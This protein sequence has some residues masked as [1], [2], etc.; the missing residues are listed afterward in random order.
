MKSDFNNT[1]GYYSAYTNINDNS[2]G[3]PLNNANTTRPN[4]VTATSSGVPPI[5]LNQTSLDEVEKNNLRMSL[6]SNAQF[7][8][9]PYCKH[10]SVTRADQTCSAGSVLCCVA[11]GGMMWLLFQALR[12]KDINCYD[13]EH[14]CI[15]CGNNLANY[16]A[17]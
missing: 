12:K 7:V 16:K 8:T 4:N 14:F 11:F 13:A 15:R 9:C 3:L 1:G 5:V 2:L 17:C 6:K 10:Q